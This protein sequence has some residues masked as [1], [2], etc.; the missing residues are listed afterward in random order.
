MFTYTNK[1]KL[2]G[3]SLCRTSHGD[4][5]SEVLLCMKVHREAPRSSGDH[6]LRSGTHE[7]PQQGPGQL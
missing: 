2:H 5:P 3:E 7:H 4:N 1:S 6:V